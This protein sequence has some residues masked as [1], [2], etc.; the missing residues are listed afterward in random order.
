[1]KLY[2]QLFWV[3][4]KIGALTLG[5]GYAMLPL[6]EREIVRKKKWIDAKEFIDMLAL[7][8]SAPG[9][10]AIN[11]S[12]FVGCK[13][14]G[15]KGSIVT[16][17]GCALPSFLIILL[18]AVVFTGVRDNEV[19]MRVFMGIRPAIVALIAA[20]VWKMAKSAQVTWHNAFIPVG[21]ALLIGVFGVSPV[22][23]IFVAIVGGLAYGV[24][25]GRVKPD[26]GS[27]GSSRPP[28]GQ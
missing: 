11:T 25:F 22:V 23:V 6:L 18:V 2:L 20:P 1:M 16:S 12:V 26:A 10:I 9:V 7:A 28:A 4:F 17:L 21:A 24:W 13:I 27:K 15:V 3:F 14:R 19:V 8:Q 5:G